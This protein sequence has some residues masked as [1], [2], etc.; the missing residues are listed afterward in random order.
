MFVILLIEKR[1]NFVKRTQLDLLSLFSQ[2]TPPPY[3]I[4]TAML[5]FVHQC[6]PPPPPSRDL[7][8]TTENNE[9]EREIGIE[10]DGGRRR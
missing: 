10:R 8:T 2:S 1:D 6:P 4:T 5:R 3:T 7:S 9:R